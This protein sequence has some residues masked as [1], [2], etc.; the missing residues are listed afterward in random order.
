MQPSWHVSVSDCRVRIPIDL[1]IAV[2]DLFIFAGF[3]H[4]YLEIS[5][6][7]GVKLHTTNNRSFSAHCTA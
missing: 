6:N 2:E 1:C 5:Y 4:T 7:T 3:R